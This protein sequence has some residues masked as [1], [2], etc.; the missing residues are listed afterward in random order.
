MFCNL[1]SLILSGALLLHISFLLSLKWSFLNPFFHDPNHTYGPGADFFAL[2]QVGHNA[3]HGTS[4]YTTLEVETVRDN[5][6]V[7]YFYPFRYIPV[8]AY[9]L[10]IVLNL[11]ESRIAYHLWIIFYEILLSV[12]IFL[13][14][15]ISP[16]RKTATISTAGWL[17]FSPYYLELYMGQFS[18]LMGTFIFLMG[19]G[20]LT[21]RLRLFD[22]AWVVS[23]L[24]KLNTL[25]MAPL[26][27]RIRRI[28]LII[29]TFLIIILS[30]V[31][32]FLKFPADLALFLDNFKLSGTFGENFHSGNHGFQSFLYNAIFR[33]KGFSGSDPVQIL[34][35]ITL[36]LIFLVLS[37][38]FL[39]TF[40]PKKLDVI[41]NLALWMSTYFLTYKHVWEHHYVMLLPVLVLLYLHKSSIST[42]HSILLLIVYLLLALPTPFY[43]FNRPGTESIYDPSMYWTRLE[44]F[45]YHLPKPLAVGV[46]YGYLVHLHLKKIFKKT[47]V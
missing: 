46:L 16:D 38:S 40:L 23:V 19:Y 10:G 27:L 37:T 31:P 24:L 28:R 14:W 30:S 8:T 47:M 2:Y 18:F 7:P 36:P 1:R 13:T 6:V 43:F 20:H 35:P 39:M 34:F 25:L 12:N 4:L 44:D 3:L 5:L 33:Y 45:L 32:Y 21:G 29:W 11:F 26:V 15:Q 9:T 41:E 42:P 17:A 22:T